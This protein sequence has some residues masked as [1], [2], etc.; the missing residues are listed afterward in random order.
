MNWTTRLINFQAPTD[1]SPGGAPAE[2]PAQQ[3]D[4]SFIPADFH[5]DGKPDTTKFMERYQ[6]LEAEAAQRAEA[7]ALVPQD[8]AYAFTLPED[9]KIEGLGLPED[10]KIALD[11]DNE[12][13]KPLL[14]DA[15]AL[16]KDIGAP[17][18]AG[19]K[20]AALIARLDATRYAMAT[21]TQ[22]AEYD[23][24]G[25]PA[26]VSARMA[27]V[28]RALES[29]L[30]EDDASAVMALTQSAGA[31][32]GLEK[33]LSSPSLAAPVSRPVQRTREDMIKDYYATPSK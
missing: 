18:D 33:L 6:S 28:K 31:F 4:L 20:M 3:D 19:E 2:P 17:K 27:T 14:A 23:K 30:S 25:T 24:L 11:L 13:Y 9:F 5:V 12:A 15:A 29:R 21:Q 1:P 22:K 16:L 10:F 8:G 32:R 7:A 26:Q